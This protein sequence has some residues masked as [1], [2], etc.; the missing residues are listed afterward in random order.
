MVYFLATGQS[1]C[2]TDSGIPCAIPFLYKGK[3]YD[4]CID[5]DNGGVPWCYIKVDETL[6]VSWGF[7]N[8]TG[9]RNNLWGT[10]NDISCPNTPG[11]F[12]T[13]INNCY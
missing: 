3:Y 5:I 6:L 13:I 12:D 4:S 8:Y 7:T 2:R 10:C 11:I 1:V 9:L